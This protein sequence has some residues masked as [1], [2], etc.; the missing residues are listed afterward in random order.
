VEAP[1]TGA[2]E[3]DHGRLH[4]LDLS[5]IIEFL[6]PQTE[7]PVASGQPGVAVVTAFYPDR[8]LMPVLRYWTDDLMRPSVDPLCPCGLVTTSI[9]EILGRADQM[10]TVGGQNY[11]PQP[12]G[13]ALTVFRELVQPPRFLVRTEER[14]EAQ[15]TVV[16]VE[17]A[18]PLSEPD[19]ARLVGN[20]VEAIPLS[21]AIHV[22]AGM[23]KCEVRL[24]P[25][26]SIPNPFRYKLQG[27][28]PG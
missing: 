3:C 25:A 27:P 23:V 8:E 26:G 1:S 12:V 5:G 11:Y 24:V 22:Q 10:V 9:E 20:I 16:E 19:A 17:C 14:A 2:F 6:D 7:R 28:S 21:R 15:C 4:F 13:D 18:A